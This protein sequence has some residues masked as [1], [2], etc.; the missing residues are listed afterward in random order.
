MKIDIAID[1]NSILDDGATAVTVSAAAEVGGAAKVIDFG[2][3]Y[4][5]NPV[6]AVTFDI[7]SADRT[8]A[9]ETYDLQV[10][11]SSTSVFT[12]VEG[13]ATLPILL[14]GKYTIVSEVKNRYMRAYYVNGGTTPILGRNSVHYASYTK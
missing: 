6:L 9:D 11:F 10:E 13:E 5:R 2:A 8:T 7:S 4:A 3:D 14:L 12:A 1:N